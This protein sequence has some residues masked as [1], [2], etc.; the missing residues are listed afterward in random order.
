MAAWMIL[1][2]HVDSMHEQ[3]GSYSRFQA[4]H[5]KA[6]P[7][8]H[9]IRQIPLEKKYVF[10]DKPNNTNLESIWSFRDIDGNILAEIRPTIKAESKTIFLRLKLYTLDSA[11]IIAFVTAL[12]KKNEIGKKL[13]F[14]RLKI[15]PEDKLT[16]SNCAGIKLSAGDF[17]EQL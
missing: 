9:R 5:R 13:G 12:Q 8:I 2:N 6:L 7:P 17:N 11:V 14:H 1:Q 16:S 10:R 15:I 4:I 3:N